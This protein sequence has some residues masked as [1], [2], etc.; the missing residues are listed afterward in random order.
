MPRFFIDVPPAGENIIISGDDARHIGR[1][2]R[3]AAGE[4]ITVCCGGRDYLCRLE[5]ISDISV[6]AKIISVEDSKEPSVNLILYQALPKLDKLELIIQKAVELGASRIVPVMTKRC[7]SRPDSAQFEKKRERLQRISLEAAKQSGR[8]IIPGV[9]GI[10]SFENC[11]AEMKRLDSGLICYEKGGIR[12]NQANL[13]KNGAIG[14]LVGPEGGFE[15]YEAEEAEK[16]GVKKIWL[17]DRILRCETAPLAAISIIMN[18]TD[19]I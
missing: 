18:L 4:N 8:G 7:V 6:T 15:A 5:K 10:I 1:S 9:R 12:L 17:G 19:N 11:I 2:L 16:N 14:L 13:P 3:M